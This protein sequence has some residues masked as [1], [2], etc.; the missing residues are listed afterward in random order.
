[1]V[2]LRKKGKINIA[3]YRNDNCFLE[4]FSI[5]IL[6]GRYNKYRRGYHGKNC[7]VRGGVE[8]QTGA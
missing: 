7:P 4:R 2:R 6:M 5:T 1:M 3:F 8:R